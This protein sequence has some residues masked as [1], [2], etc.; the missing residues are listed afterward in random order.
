MASP[1]IYLPLSLEVLDGPVIGVESVESGVGECC[2][3][4]PGLRSP[5]E[6]VAARLQSGPT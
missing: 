5:G 3:R 1:D 6:M 2:P 4:Y